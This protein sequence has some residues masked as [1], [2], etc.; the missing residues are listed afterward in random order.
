MKI[1]QGIYLLAFLASGLALEE[2]PNAAHWKKVLSA[3]PAPELPAVA[4]AQVKQTI[5]AERQVVT[6]A[7]V[8]AAVEINPAAAPLVVGAIAREVPEMAA[9]AAATAAAKQPAQSGAICKA[10]V[11][12]T[13]A[14]GANIVCAMCKAV[15]E[16]YPTV[17]VSAA[18]VT[19]AATKEIL[20]SVGTARPLLA[21]QLAREIANY[22]RE[23]PPVALVL[24]RAAAH[25]TNPPAPGV[26]KVARPNALEFSAS[27]NSN[28]G[29]PKNG[30]NGTHGGRNYAKP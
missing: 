17:A 18:E 16:C 25:Q 29:H 10:A 23:M 22:D 30:G 6:V 15:P 7:I 3:V 24:N 19:P 26:D 14:L 1:T 12:V 5:I 13:P 21:P 27:T 2:P 8:E 11:S 28:Q 20:R 9:V 4:A